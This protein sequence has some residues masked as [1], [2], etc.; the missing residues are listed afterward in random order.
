[1]VARWTFRGRHEG[2]FQ[3]VPTTDE[4]VTTTG[5]NN[6]RVSGGRITDGREIAGQLT[7]ERPL[8]D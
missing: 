2:E 7:R 6:F 4:Q 8:L 5:L 3:G 1:V